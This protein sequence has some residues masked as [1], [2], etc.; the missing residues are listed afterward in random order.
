M[1]TSDNCNRVVIIDDDDTVRSVLSDYLED[2]GYEVMP[3]ESPDEAEPVLKPTDILIVDVRLQSEY[4]KGVDF[5]IHLRNKDNKYESTKTIFISNFGRERVSL[6][7]QKLKFSSYEWLDKPFE[8]LELA[9]AI[10][11]S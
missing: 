3:F 1:E 4:S 9:N 11:R 2:E 6:N 5:I 8:M 10:Q 7:L